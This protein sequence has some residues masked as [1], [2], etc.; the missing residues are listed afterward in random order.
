[1]E[2]P[3]TP[4]KTRLDHFRQL[5]LEAYGENA[6]FTYYKNQIPYTMTLDEAI[7]ICGSDMVD[8]S[9]EDFLDTLQFMYLKAEELKAN[10]GTE[11]DFETSRENG[12]ALRERI[13]ARQALA[14]EHGL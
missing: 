2:R 13:V 9:D 4:E 6:A 3:N 10:T 8:A 12:R 1:M 14:R 5:A 11:I 7:D